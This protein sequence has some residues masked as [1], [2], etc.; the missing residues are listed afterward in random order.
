MHL[1]CLHHLRLDSFRFGVRIV[2]DYG[3]LCQIVIICLALNLL[4]TIPVSFSFY[5]YSYLHLFKKIC[6]FPYSCFAYCF[7]APPESRGYLLAHTNGGLN[8]MRAGVLLYCLSLCEIHC[9]WNYWNCFSYYLPKFFTISIL[10]WKC[11]CDCAVL[12]YWQQ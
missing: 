9:V 12:A 5:F 10:F 4:L 7:S 6:L 1:S 11:A 2:P 3:S 8:Q